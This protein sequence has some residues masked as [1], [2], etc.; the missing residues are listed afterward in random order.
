MNITSPRGFLGLDGIFRFSK[1]GYV[2]RGLSLFEIEK[3]G[4][5]LISPAPKNFFSKDEE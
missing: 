3:R 1:K 2:E 5:K 4:V